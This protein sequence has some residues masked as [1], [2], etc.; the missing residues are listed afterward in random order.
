M[1]AVKYLK[2][3]NAHAKNLISE[4]SY[5]NMPWFILKFFIWFITVILFFAKVGYPARNFLCDK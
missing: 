3:Y 2:S 4:R 1:N 5:I